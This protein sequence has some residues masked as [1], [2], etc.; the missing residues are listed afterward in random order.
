MM[1]LKIKILGIS[2]FILIFF[3]WN[4]NADKV[5]IPDLD[6]MLKYKSVNY[7]ISSPY[8]TECSYS[9]SFRNCEIGKNMI[10]KC[11]HYIY[12]SKNILSPF[13][14]GIIDISNKASNIKISKNKI[15]LDKI[16]KDDDKSLKDIIIIEFDYIG[17]GEEWNFT[18]NIDS[19]KI[20]FD[21]DISACSTLNSPSTTYTLTTD[22][23][24][25]GNTCFTAT[26]NDI[27]L[28][29]NNHLLYKNDDFKSIYVNSVNNFI[30]FDGFFKNAYIFISN[31]NDVE[32]YNLDFN[33]NF[34]AIQQLY[35]CNYDTSATTTINN[36]NIHHNVF[37]NLTVNGIY[38][39]GRSGSNYGYINNLTI[40][41][42]IFKNNITYKALTMVNSFL[43][44][45]IYFYDNNMTNSVDDYFDLSGATN[46]NINLNSSTHGN[47]YFIEGGLGFSDNCT[48]SS[49]VCSTTRTENGKTDYYPLCV[50]GNNPPTISTP[51]PTNNS[52]IFTGSGVDIIFNVYDLDADLLNVDVI[53]FHGD[54]SNTSCNYFAKTSGSEISCTWTEEFISEQTY[55][56][57]VNVSDGTDTYY[58]RYFFTFG[59]TMNWTITIKDNQNWQ[60]IQNA[61][62]LIYDNDGI[63]LA[64]YEGDTNLSG[65]CLFNVGAGFYYIE[66]Y[67]T[68]YDTIYHTATLTNFTSQYDT[69]YMQTDSTTNSIEFRV[70]NCL[71]LVPLN[72]T[73]VQ[74]YNTVYPLVFYSGN[75]SE[76]GTIKFNE[77][78]PID[79]KFFY[80]TTKE[81]YTRDEWFYDFAPTSDYFFTVCISEN[82]TYNI[83][84]HIQDEL[85][86]A[87]LE[88]VYLNLYTDHHILNSYYY[89]Y[90]NVSGICEIQNVTTDN[91]NLIMSKSGYYDTEYE[92]WISENEQFNYTMK[93]EED[94]CTLRVWSQDTS[95]N[96][97]LDYVNFNITHVIGNVTTLKIQ[98]TTDK[99]GRYEGNIICS[100]HLQYKSNKIY[101]DILEG[102]LNLINDSVTNLYLHHTKTEYTTTIYGY[103]LN[104]NYSLLANATKYGEMG[105]NVCAYDSG[106]LIECVESTFIIDD[107][108]ILFE[109]Y[110]IFENIGY[111]RDI[112]FK[113]SK[114]IFKD[115]S[116]TVY[117]DIMT[118]QNPLYFTIHEGDLTDFMDDLEDGFTLANF[119]WF[120]KHIGWWMI[121][122]LLGKIF[123]E[124]MKGNDKDDEIRTTRQFKRGQERDGG[125]GF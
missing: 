15:A 48:C 61:T 87:N 77:S 67:K 125:W 88:N 90:T 32:L 56:W 19:Q 70:V 102:D 18:A 97:A 79:E 84:F 25:S 76:A 11:K 51:T 35:I 75:T 119:Y 89:C 63:G 112:V 103:M 28:D 123:W 78:A 33:H 49:G 71:T 93:K 55:N 5:I 53:K 73:F 16:K 4:V 107:D 104:G 1:K 44:N 42:N 20:K 54:G 13:D 122:L 36:I 21:P 110:F 109:G 116:K 39:Y 3:C 74:Y 10:R 26:A 86:D 115:G 108:D 105:V 64:D 50:L 72:N 80:K 29:F 2:L 82:L 45:E 99:N 101:Y 41:N 94:I 124:A 14:I 30:A 43:N 38:V 62:I 37:H 65:E 23:N 69:Y 114:P 27:T 83:T 52:N 8:H 91:Y 24:V 68:G 100:Q 81:G 95:N 106:T 117:V 92:P 98:G 121:L 12:D 120:M 58:G 31:S 46:L 111:D 34:G 60:P 57:T 113:W 6:N 47:Y 66:V 22:I 59:N 85:S 9:C 40:H 118:Q 7:D 17:F 96:L